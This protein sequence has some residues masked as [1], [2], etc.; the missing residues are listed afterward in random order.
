VTEA[1]RLYPYQLH[2]VDF[3]KRNRFALLADEMGVGKSPQSIVAAE[4]LQ[5]ILVI[6]PAVA[7]INWQREFL[8]FAG[9]KSRVIG[10]SEPQPKSDIIITN[11]ERVAKNPDHYARVNWDVVILDESHYVKEQGAQRTAAIFGAGGV[12]HSSK[13]VW[14]LTGTPAPNHAGELWVMLNAFG[15]TRLTYDQFV[16]RYC[17]Y[18]RV[19]NRY[20]AKRITGTNANTSHEVRAM[21]EQFALRRKL[22]D[23]VKDIPPISFHTQ[24]ID[25]SYDPLKEYPELKDKVREEL[26]RLTEKLGTELL[27][28]VADEYLLNVVAALSP[29]ISSLRR[30]HGLKKAHTC[31]DLIASELEDGAYKKIIIFAVHND[32]I[33]VTR[34]RLT[35]FNPVKIVGGTSP[36]ARQQAID[37]FQRDSDCRV[38]IGNIGAAGTAITLTAA[39]NVAFI[40]KD[41]VPGNNAQAAGRAHRIGQRHPVTVKFFCLPGFDEMLT[42]ILAR[43]AQEIS[44]FIN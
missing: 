36:A 13:R 22:M 7:K 28:N 27:D 3:L 8:K 2:G 15:H 18:L 19:L 11:Y 43:K 16:E 12:A 33:E 31:S 5:N 14:C 6:C 24:V 21:L 9:R 44:G 41:Y 23:V 30:Y 4:D 42:N 38:F 37:R 39:H 17:T 1:P 34:Q 29:S 20:Q 35:E 10:C 26:Q 32:V 25:S 40:E